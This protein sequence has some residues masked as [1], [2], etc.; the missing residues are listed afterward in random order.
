MHHIKWNRGKKR[1]INRNAAAA[2]APHIPMISSDLNYMENG[3]RVCNWSF[4]EAITYAAN[5][6]LYVPIINSSLVLHEINKLTFLK[7]FIYDAQLMCVSKPLRFSL[8]NLY[9]PFT[10]L[11][12]SQ[13]TIA[14][15]NC[16]NRS[17]HGHRNPIAVRS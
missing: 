10:S 14:V 7:E 15:W 9:K 2:A 8:R 3:T 11:A 6:H 12:T 13:T 16:T 1:I 5:D 17:V 4:R